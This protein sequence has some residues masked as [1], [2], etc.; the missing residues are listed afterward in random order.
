MASV[1]VIESSNVDLV[2][3]KLEGGRI[4]GSLGG[5]ENWSFALTVGLT[6]HELAKG[7][8]ALRGNVDFTSIWMS[9]TSGMAKSSTAPISRSISISISCA[10]L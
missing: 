3:R 4:G 10:I 9:S 1:Q 7:Q 5:I 8:K 2:R 6:M